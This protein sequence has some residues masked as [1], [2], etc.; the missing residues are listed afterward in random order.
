MQPYVTKPYIILNTTL[1]IDEKKSIYSI[2]LV[3]LLLLLMFYVVCLEK[4]DVSARTTTFKLLPSSIQVTMY[5]YIQFLIYKLVLLLLYCIFN[6][7]TQLI[8]NK[9]KYLKI[10]LKFIYGYGYIL[11][12]FPPHMYKFICYMDRVKY[13]IFK[14]QIP[15]N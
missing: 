11:Y 12:V 10:L 7:N 14:H 1:T 13:N 4:N 2:L 8:Q 5:H 15:T 6:A 9:I 3:M